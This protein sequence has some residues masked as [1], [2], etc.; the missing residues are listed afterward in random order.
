MG[1]A[2]S[3]WSWAG[4]GAALLGFGLLCSLGAAPPAFAWSPSGNPVDTVGT[5]LLPLVVYNPHPM[6]LGPY[7]V[8]QGESPPKVLVQRLDDDGAWPA[9]WSVDAPLEVSPVSGNQQSA[10]AAPDSQ[11]GI[12][13]VWQ[14]T[15]AGDQD[16][17]VQ[18][19][20]A[21]RQL[22]MTAAGRAV[23][24]RPGAQISPAIVP[25]YTNQAIMVWEDQ[26][27][28]ALQGDIYAQ[29]VVAVSADSAIFVWVPEDGAVACSATG[30]QRTPVAVGDGGG[31]VVVVWE[32]L[33]APG[34]I[35]LY[36]QRL[37]GDGNLLWGSPST[38]GTPVVTAVCEQL[39]PAVIADGTG[40]AI[41]VWVDRR[42]CAD[43]SPD[44]DI[45]GARLSATGAINWAKAIC[46]A[47]NDQRN[48]AIV[49]DGS[50]G[51]LV[52]WE[53]TRNGAS[54]IYC[55]RVNSSGDR[56]AGWPA[57]GVCIC[58]AA[59]SQ[60][61]PRIVSDGAHGAL[62]TWQDARSG[63]NQVYL[64][65]VGASGNLST[66]PVNGYPLCSV[67]AAQEA[68][69]AARAADGGAIVGWQDGRGMIP[70]SVHIYAQKMDLPALAGVGEGVE[71]GWAPAHPNPFATR[72]SIEL[73]LAMAQKATV[74]VFDLSGRRQR[75]L[76]RGWLPPGK[77]TVVWDGTT[78]D[79][80]E[81]PTGL[82]FVRSRV[83]SLER[84]EKLLRLR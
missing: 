24:G 81:A 66:G 50:G 17:W 44:T 62:V 11:G 12:F 3:R 26:R 33:R 7:F 36:A 48:P 73:V 65:R 39:D 29:K 9:P 54:D 58:S 70:G 4:R 15:V 18:R 21:T 42:K 16:I 43:P 76:L 34:E 74:E 82:Y 30:V 57:D 80:G 1:V 5:N 51:A 38:D 19:V 6:F 63:T 46:A 68:P 59:N 40:G 71:A 37:D 2:S 55:Q 20:S 69:A 61:N 45:W 10:A 83:G 28:G 77:R 47:S 53:D 23:C 31:G 72:A 41:I 49:P 84:R 8:W 64:Q 67:S 60:L 27:N 13:V 78:E 52:A 22:M 79:G 25:V 75:V 32:D 56:V 35:D 14:Q